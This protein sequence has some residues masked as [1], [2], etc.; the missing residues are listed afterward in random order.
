ML[1]VSAIFINCCMVTGYKARAIAISPESTRRFSSPSPRI[2]P[3][4]S[5]LLSERK[6]VM[7]NISRRMRS[8]D[9]VT[10]SIPIGSESLYVPSLA[11]S[12][13]HLPSR[14][15]EKLCSLAGAYTFSPMHSTVKFFS[16]AFMNSSGESPFRSRTTR[17]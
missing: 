9:T 3:T 12:E 5:I 1:P 10:S 13:Y 2:P 11:V 17:L 4:K 8:E 7:P 6:S 16:I 14:Y 15:S